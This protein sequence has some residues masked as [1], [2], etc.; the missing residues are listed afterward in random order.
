[1]DR[2]Y[3]LKLLKKANL[4][5]D[6]SIRKVYSKYSRE[7][8]NI[9]VE[10]STLWTHLY[11]VTPYLIDEFEHE[12]A[13][14]VREVKSG[15]S[16]YLYFVAKHAAH[17]YTAPHFDYRNFPLMRQREKVLSRVRSTAEKFASVNTIE[18]D[19]TCLYLLYFYALLVNPDLNW[20]TVDYLANGNRY[21]QHGTRLKGEMKS[22]VRKSFV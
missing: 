6:A 10:N 11:D 3:D 21:H 15:S 9:R 12:G 17:W 18:F 20:I 7:L 8:K 19:A 14:H 4:P 16:G 22:R 2:Y 1:M 5:I 13:K